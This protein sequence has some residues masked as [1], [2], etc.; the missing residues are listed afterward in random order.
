MKRF[1]LVA[2]IGL[3][4]CAC[5]SQPSENA[6]QTA[7]ALTD[8]AK[9]SETFTT[10]PTDTSTPSPTST[11]IPTDTPT[12]KPTLTSEPTDT[13]TPTP[14]LRIIEGDAEDYILQKTDLP[15]RYIL[16]SGDSTPHE[17]TEILSARGIEDG[18]AYLEATGRI[19][20]WIVWYNLI[21]VLN[22]PDLSLIHI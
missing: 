21:D 15:H 1:T 6:V 12:P 2:I 3:V 18:K 10:V 20:G 16:R 17:N 7:I 9:P 11:D 22:A 19:K 13:L 8:V 5:S 4:L 14:D